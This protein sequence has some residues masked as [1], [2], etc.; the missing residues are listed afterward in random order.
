MT[1][2]ML[3]DRVAIVTG[4]GRGMGRAMT[5]GLVKAGAR[6]VGNVA[7]S[8]SELESVAAEINETVGPDRF[9][10]LVADVS[11]EDECV[12]MVEEARRKFGAVHI[13]VNNA[14]RGHYFIYQAN[15]GQPMNFWTADSDM[16]RMMVE[17]NIN[18]PFYMAKAV[19]PNMIAQGW[20]RIINIG[21]T[22]RTMQKT[23]NS[24]YGVTKAA[25]E[26]ETLIWSKDLEGTGVT[27]NT[28]APGGVTDTGMVYGDLTGRKLLSPEIMVDPLVCLVST[29]ADGITGK[30]F[31]AQNW[32]PALPPFE[33]LQKAEA[34]GAFQMPEPR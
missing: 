26:S 28:L 24:P 18:G 31:V 4:A 17:T 9:L 19:A 6:V 33:A 16:W 29:A 8:K 10:S 34:P 30:R 14:A 3:E 27:V 11:Q 7:Q 22:V 15:P 1:N 12:R 2:T 25:I 23:Q 32:D 13:L 5:L 21:A 20:G